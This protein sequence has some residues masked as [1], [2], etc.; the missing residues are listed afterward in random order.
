VARSFRYLP[1]LRRAG[2][3]LMELMV[4]IC[5]IITMLAV[6]APYYLKIIQIARKTAGQ[7]T[8]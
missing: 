7:G 4:V 6:C 5:I 2:H 3:S 8:P 1:K